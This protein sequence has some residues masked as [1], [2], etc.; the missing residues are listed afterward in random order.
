M[1]RITIALLATVA[2]VGLMSSAYAADLIVDEPA[3]VDVVD[4]GGNWDGPFIGVFAGYGW[5]TL[6][7]GI[8]DDVFTGDT[9]DLTGWFVG[10]DAGFNVTVGSGLVA[11]IVGD[12]AWSDINGEDTSYPTTFDVDWFGSVRGRLGF[13]GGAF[14]PYLTAGVAFAGATADYDGDVDSN[15]HVGWTAGAGV[16]F[17]A[18]ESLSIDLLY[19]F[20]DYGEQT[21][22][23][24]PDADLS[25]VTHTVQVGLHWNF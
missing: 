21:Y 8:T 5:G 18:T 12:I 11:G 10:L 19:R 13:D 16:E 4:L 15:T 23:I 3:P 22:A 7:Q 24:V 17:A 14:M 1:K 2:S 25:F 6:T 20:S 9:L